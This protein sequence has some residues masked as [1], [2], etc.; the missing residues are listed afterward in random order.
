MRLAMLT[1]QAVV[2][3]PMRHHQIT[4]K[5]LDRRMAPVSILICALIRQSRAL[6][7]LLAC[8]ELKLSG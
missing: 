5:Q 7:Q 4:I 6:V 1:S 8:K 2:Q 3:D